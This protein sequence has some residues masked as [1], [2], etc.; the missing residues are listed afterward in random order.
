MY[1]NSSDGSM[2]PSPAR[3]PRI[4]TQNNLNVGAELGYTPITLVWQ[5]LSYYVPLPRGNA[6]SK[7]LDVMDADSD[8]D[9]A[10]KKRLLNDITG[11]QRAVTGCT[12]AASPHDM[13]A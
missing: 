6:G 9:V 11:A 13:L 5:G 12:A 10:G 7:S 4:H 2:S 8:A 1:G 3:T